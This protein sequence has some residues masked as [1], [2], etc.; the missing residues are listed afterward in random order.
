LPTAARSVALTKEGRDVN[1]RLSANA[2]GQDHRV[3]VVWGLQ[4]TAAVTPAGWEWSCNRGRPPSIPPA[5]LDVPF[6]PGSS[7]TTKAVRARV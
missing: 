5:S 4:F 2:E 7:G 1:N 3:G 6:A